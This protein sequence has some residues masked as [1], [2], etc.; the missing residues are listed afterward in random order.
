MISYV[1]NAECWNVPTD[2]VGFENACILGGN[3][4]VSSFLLCIR[5]DFFTTDKTNKSDNFVGHQHPMSH[6]QPRQP[7]KSKTS[8]GL[9]RIA[10]Q[11][12]NNDRN[13]HLSKGRRGR[14]ITMA[15]ARR[16]N[17]G[18]AGELSPNTKAHFFASGLPKDWSEADDIA[19][20]AVPK[21]LRPP[22]ILLQT[23]LLVPVQTSGFGAFA[24]FH[25]EDRSLLDCPR[26]MRPRDG[27]EVS[28]MIEITR[29][30]F[31]SVKRLIVSTIGASEPLGWV[32]GPDDGILWRWATRPDV[33]IKAVI[34][35][36]D[37]RYSSDDFGNEAKFWKG[38][39]SWSVVKKTVG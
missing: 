30:Q 9:I 27:G 31:T 13:E 17:A 22:P 29:D 16:Q 20:L 24:M 32:Y 3:S 38:R 23:S 19:H 5:S 1:E 26:D 39:V 21:E 34:R 2:A 8:D 4:P 37:V 35:W 6:S 28:G 11:M 18:R 36:G 10:S 15:K 7:T 25:T 14:H 33:K 12:R